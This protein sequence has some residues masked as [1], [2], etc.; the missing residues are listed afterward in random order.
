[1][2]L[3]PEEPPAF[4]I[5]RARGSSRFVLVADHA[6]NRIPKQLGD[7]GLDEVERQRHIAWDIGIA[8]VGHYLSERLDAVFVHQGYS[9]LVIDCNRPPGSPGSVLTVSE[10]TRVP[11]NE[12]ITDA[13]RKQREDEVFW[14][15]QNSIQAVL[16]E[17]RDHSQKSVVIALHSFTPVFMDA[18]RS[19]EVGVLYERDA[20]LAEPLLRVLRAEPGLNVGDNEPY[21]MSLSTDFTMATHALGRGLL[22]VELELRQDLITEDAQC[23]VWAERLSRWLPSALEQAEL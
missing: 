1:M 16:D 8:C 11:G 10:R 13:Q 21:A 22:H 9:R 20:R 14:P 7:L 6:S 3:S 17:R 2:L 12:G 4:Q 18:Q 15:Y 23:A 5:E 19:V